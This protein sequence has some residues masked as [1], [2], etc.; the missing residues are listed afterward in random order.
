[1]YQTLTGQSVDFLLISKDK[2]GSKVTAGGHQVQAQVI[3]N[4]EALQARQEKL[5]VQDNSD[6]SY[7]F[8]YCPRGEGLATL[9]VLVEGQSVRGSPFDWQ[10]S[11]VRGS[12]FNSTLNQGQKSKVK[13]YQQVPAV[14][15]SDPAFTEGMHSWKLQL[16]SY[17]PPN[18][19]RNGQ[20]VIIG[21]RNYSRSDLYDYAFQ[22]KRESKWCWCFNS[23][24]QDFSRSD[25]RPSS[26]TSVQN[27][28]IF[29]I[30]LNFD[31]R[32]LIVYNARSKQAE[33]F[34][35]VEGNPLSPLISPSTEDSLRPS[36][37]YLTLD[38]Q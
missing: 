35:E 32:K 1:M 23:A 17:S 12:P 26:I 20:E 6:G 13:R 9:T 30:F 38:V 2:T 33:L 37:M 28:D 11:S 10:V 24:K 18:Q 16:V 5:A 7:S 27:K 22:L 36:K 29:T 8:S 31:T 4:S 3:F 19:K 14:K 15:E 25:G 34:T 21:V